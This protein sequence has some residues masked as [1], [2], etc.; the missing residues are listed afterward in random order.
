MHARVNRF[1]TSSGSS[2]I[3]WCTW[4]SIRS[5]RSSRSNHSRQCEAVRLLR[6]LIVQ[7]GQT[8]TRLQEHQDLAPA[9]PGRCGAGARRAWGQPP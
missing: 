6:V 9:E 4:R 2:S 7:L 8:S 1:R 5:Y 3:I